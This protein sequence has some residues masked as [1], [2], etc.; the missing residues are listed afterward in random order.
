MQNSIKM[1]R[2]ILGILLI[3]I[4]LFKSPI[5]RIY[6][7]EAREVYDSAAKEKG[8]YYLVTVSGQRIEISQRDYLI[9]NIIGIGGMIALLVGAILIFLFFVNLTFYRIKHRDKFK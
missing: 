9:H 8:V 2:L 7:F 1:K 3:F 4:G 5:P 6:G